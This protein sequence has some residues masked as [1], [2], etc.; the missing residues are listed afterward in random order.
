[1]RYVAL[2]RVDHDGIATAPRACAVLLVLLLAGAVLLRPGPAGAAPP[3][4]VLGTTS[5][6]QATGLLDV[7]VPM[8]EQS[9]G[10]RVKTVAV[11]AP[12]ALI[13][14]TRGEVDVLLVHAPEDERRFVAEG[15]G[16]DRRLVHPRRF[17]AGRAAH[18]PA[19][20]RRGTG[21]R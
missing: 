16:V 13:L 8:F 3:E 9:S 17:R 10:Y 5:S 19:Q 21:H 12:Q 11:S 20:C 18:R 4:I 15:N 14:G 6:L 7:L 2:F 1:M